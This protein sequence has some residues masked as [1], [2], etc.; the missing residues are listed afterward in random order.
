MTLQQHPDDRLMVMELKKM[1]IE[2]EKPAS[3]IKAGHG[4]GV[5]IPLQRLAQ[6]IL[7]NK[8]K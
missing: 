7:Q 8:F 1:N 6:V 4:H 2:L 5:C 3:K